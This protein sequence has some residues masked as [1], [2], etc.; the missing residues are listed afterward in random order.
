MTRAEKQQLFIMVLGGLIT[1]L[2]LD[3][4]RQHQANKQGTQKWIL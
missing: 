1:G 3:A 4:Y 2:A